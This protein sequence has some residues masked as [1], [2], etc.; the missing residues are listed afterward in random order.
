MWVWL[1]RFILSIDEIFPL[2]GEI[3]PHSNLQLEW[4]I[5]AVF[6]PFTGSMGLFAAHSLT[7]PLIF[8][9]FRWSIINIIIMSSEE[10]RRH[11]AKQRI[12]DD[13]K[14]PAAAVIMQFDIY[15]RLLWQFAPEGKLGGNIWIIER[16]LKSNRFRK[17]LPGKCVWAR[18]GGGVVRLFLF[19]FFSPPC[20]PAAF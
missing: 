12:D 4:A 14:S 18:G 10:R 8:S 19:V 2:F 13:A 17:M 6:N 15:F 16:K 5:S 11:V 7:L 3:H 9:T 20:T 1:K